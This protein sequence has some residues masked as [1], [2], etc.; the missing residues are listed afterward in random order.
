MKSKW[1]QPSSNK[2]IGKYLLFNGIRWDKEILDHMVADEN[3]TSDPLDTMEMT[4]FYI[5][6]T[7]Y[8]PWYPYKTDKAT[9]EHVKFLLDN[10]F[11][12]D[13]KRKTMEQEKGGFM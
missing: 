4:R 5:D 11:D 13:Y 12:P 9:K 6:I 3:N 7:K 10:K 8:I 2:V 1:W